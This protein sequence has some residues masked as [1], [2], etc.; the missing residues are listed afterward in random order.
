[1]SVLSYLLGGL[2]V[3][4]GLGWV[5]AH[6]LH[7]MALLPIG[8]VL[9]TGLSVYL[10][11]RHYGSPGK[12]A[13]SDWIEQRKTDQARW[14]Q[15]A[16]RPPELDDAAGPDAT[17]AAPARTGDAAGAAIADSRPAQR[18]RGSR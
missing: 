17:P 6:F 4:G 2:I 10:I 13:T 9:G 7:V 5:G 15:I 1:M 16:G 8:I 11:V 12:Q 18:G 3:Y 14:A